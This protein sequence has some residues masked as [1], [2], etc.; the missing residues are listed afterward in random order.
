MKRITA[1]IPTFNEQHNIVDAIKNGEIQ[2]TTEYKNKLRDQKRKQI[3]NLISRNAVDPSNNLPHPPQRIEN[4]LNEAKVKIDEFHTAEEPLGTVK[5]KKI[6][7][8]KYYH[9]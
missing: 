6:T 5:G 7:P 3:V 9:P 1:I 8:Q 4:A 2:L